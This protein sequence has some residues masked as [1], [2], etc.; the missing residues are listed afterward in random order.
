MR[1]VDLHICS[2][3]ICS[4]GS[5]RFVTTILIISCLL[6]LYEACQYRMERIID[7]YRTIIIL[8]SGKPLRQL[9]EPFGC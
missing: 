7:F 6:L 8:D 2:R 9:S 4:T 5:V 1:S 3:L